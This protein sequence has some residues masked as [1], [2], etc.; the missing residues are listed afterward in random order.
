[1]CDLILHENQYAPRQCFLIHNF[2]FSLET[3]VVIAI[4]RATPRES[5]YPH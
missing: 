2:S 5:L 4:V 1:M 3:L